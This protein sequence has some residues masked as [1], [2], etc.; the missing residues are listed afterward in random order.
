MYG[1]LNVFIAALLARH[2]ATP[3][4][5]QQALE[6]SDVQAFHFTPTA[7]TYRDVS[8][9]TD[10]IRSTRES[11]VLSFGSCSFREPVDDLAAL[12]LL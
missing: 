10:E 8:I 2:G 6:E 5:V 4:L 7:L 11:F 9:S 3:A 12:G 1:Y